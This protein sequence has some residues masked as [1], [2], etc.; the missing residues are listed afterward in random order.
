VLDART[1]TG[2]PTRRALEE[3]IVDVCIVNYPK[4]P[5]PFEENYELLLKVRT[6]TCSYVYMCVYVF[7][8]G[9]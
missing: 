6:P 4:D 5:I 1:H 2:A 3:A 7:F 9:G 8:K